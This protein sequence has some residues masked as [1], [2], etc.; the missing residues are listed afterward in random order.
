MLK[1][2]QL[3]TLLLLAIAM[4]SYA[5]AMPFLQDDKG[6]Q[7]PQ[8][9]R[10]AQRP[11]DEDKGK[12]N[13]STDILQTILIDE[14]TIPDSLLHPRWKIQRTTPITYD[15][16]NQSAMDLRRP[17]ALHYEVTYNDSLDVYVI[18]TK[19]GSTYVAAPIMMD[20]EEYMD[21]SMKQEMAIYYRGK[22]SEIYEAKGK[23]KFD[24]TDMHFDLGPAEKIFGPGGVRI[25]TQGTAELKLGAT[26]KNI[27]NPSLPI[28]NRKTT[29]INF[30]EKINLSVNGKVGDKVNMN[31]NYNTD[32]TFDFDSQNMK[33]KYEGKEDE[34]IKLVEAG[35]TSFPSNSSLV[36][37]T[38][39]LFG[40]RTDMQFGKL[41]LQTVV[42][43]KK[44]SS[45]S[46][47][48]KGGTQLTSF[49]IDVA[50]YE[51]NRHFFLSQYF[52]S[53]YDNGMSKLP[54]VMTGVSISR[55]EIWV[56]NKTGTTTNT[57]DIVALTDLGEPTTISNSMWTGGG[58][59]V[60]A[61][62]ANTEYA[63]MTSQ[64]ADARDI[65]QTSSVLEG[66]G[67]VGG[68]DFEKLQSARLLTSSEYTLNTALGYVSLKSTLSTDQVLAVA[69]EYTYGGVTY[70]V[71][72]FAADVTD[73]SQALFVKALK[74]TS[75]DPSQGNWDLMMKNVY[76]LAS[77]VEKEKFKLDVKYQSD[78]T[79]V[80]LNY[81]PESQVKSTTLLKVL[82]ADR[83][84]NNNKAHSNGYFDYVDGY[85]VSN[86]RVFFP[87][88]EPFGSYIYDY[89]VSAGVDAETA[90]GYAFTELYTTTKTSAKQIAEK[91]KYL[92]VGQ[93]RGTSANVISLGAYNVPQGSVTVTAGG[94]TLTEGSD[95]SV[96]YS[97]G[98]V[99]ILNQSIIDAGTTVTATYES[100]SDYGQMRKT[101][102]GLNWEYD[103]SKNFQLSGTLQHLSE[104]SL[105]TKVSMGNE[106]VNNTLWGINMNWKHE[107]QWLTNVLDKLPGLHLTQPSQISFT[108]EFAQLIAAQAGGTQ[109]NASYLDDFESSTD[110]ID[111]STPT[112]WV[113]SS[114][115]SM[116]S[117]QSDKTGLTSGYNRA[118]MAWYTIDPLFTR[119]SSSLTP[120]HIKSDLDQ[121][122]DPYVR[123]VYVKELYPNRDQSSYSGATSTLS[124]LNVAYYPTERGPYNFN[125]D[126]STTGELNNATDHWG[127]MM[128][129]L[130]TSDFE[131]ANVE[132]IE[133]WLMDPFI[134][135]RD[136]ADASSYGGDLYFNLGEV[137]EDILRDGKKFYES[138]LPV[139][140]TSSYSTTQWGKIPEQATTTYSFSTSSGTRELQDL[141]LNGLNDEEELQFSSYQ[142]FL[143]Q[144]QGK[145]NAAVWDSIYNDPAHDN[146][147]YF[148]GSDYDE[149]E[150]SILR[151]Y[152]YINNPQGNS[153]DSDGRTESYDTS[154]KTSPDVEDI[155]QD[156]TLNE[157]EKYYQY[158]VSLRPEDFVV[159][160]NFIVDKRETNPTRRNGTSGEIDWYLFRI[161][162]DEYEKVYGSI[163][164]FSS[165]RFMRMFLTGFEKPVVLRFASLDLVRG[166]WRIYDGNLESSGAQTGTLTTASMSIEENNDKTPVNYVLPPG[167]TREQD[168]TQ[169]QLVEADEQALALNVSNLASGES[170]CIY[171]NTT[172]DLR[173]YKTI[174]LFVHANALET[175]TTN[176]Q[177]DELAIFVRLGSDYKNNYYEYQ[178][179]L[180]LTPAGYYDR[181]SLSGCQ[182]VWPEENMLDVALS[183]FTSVK[184]ERNKAKA[185]GTASYT[186][187]YSVYDSDNPQNKVT[188][189]GNPTL[190]E[191]K[192]LIIGVR[193]LSA[194]TKSGEIWVNELRVKDYESSGGWAANG[195]LNVQLSDLG[196]VNVQGKYIS[197]GF[198]GLE[199]GVS[200]R[201]QDSESTFSFTTN[202]ELGKF[203]PDKANVTIP[204]YYSVTR[205]KTTP[206]YNPLD[207]DV[208][209][210]DALDDAADDAERDS[211]K[212]IAITK[213]VTTNF[214]LS[215][216]KVGIQNKKHPMPYD[217]ANFTFFYSHSHTHTQGET[218]V[219]ENEDNWRGGF[220]YLWTPVYKS[221][222]PFK[223][224][225]TKSKWADIAKKFGLN[226]LPQSVGFNTEL[227]RYYYELQERDLEA[228]ENAELPVTFSSQFLWNR[229][230][231][232]RWDFTKN[233]HMTFQS[234]TQ[235]EIEE[236]Y[237]AVNKD[238]YPERYQAWKDSVWQSI[239]HLGTPLDYQQTFQL[240]YKPP[241]NLIPIFDWVSTDAT[242][243]AAYTWERGS[244][245]E[246]STSLGNTI[247]T[248]R[249]LNV[250]GQFDLV[251]LY[252]HVPFLKATNDRFGKDKSKTQINKEKKQK[253]TEKANKKKQQEAEQKA[254]EQAIAEGKDPDE[255]VRA[256]RQ[257]QK[258]EEQKKKTLP[259][260]KRSYEK[261]ITLKPDTTID[262]QHGKK[263]KRIIVTAKTEDGKQ[264]KLKYK[265]VDPNKIRITT[266]VD[267]ATKV[268]INV[269]PKPEWDTYK[270]YR[271]AQSIARVAMM[272]RS[273]SITYRNQYSMSLPGFMPTIGDA[274]G[275]TKNNDAGLLSPGLAF[276]FG[277]VGD[278]YVNTALNNGWLLMN[279]SVATPATSN[280]TEDL[281]LRLKLEPWRHLTIDLNAAYTK[282]TAKS[283]QYMYDGCPTT[284]SGTFSMTTISI[285]SAFEGMGNAKNGYRSKTFE[286]FCNSLETYR[287][288]VE[289]RYAGTTYPTGTAYAGQTFS[290]ANGAVEQ[291]SADVMIPAF[292]ASYT[293]MGDGL[294]IFPALSRLLP[295]W[296]IKYTGLSK[297]PWLR[298]HFKSV[299][300]N[301]S[302]KSI[303]AVGSYQSYSTFVSLIGGADMGFITD[304]TTGD[305]MPSS[306]YNVSTVSLNEAFSPLL[307][308]DCTLNNGL[309][310]KLEYKQTRVLTLSMT[311]VQLN[312]T[313]SKDWVVGF[314]YK[315]SNFN[316][317]GS[318]RSRAI[319]KAQ[320]KNKG[321]GTDADDENKKAQENQKSQNS[322]GGVNHDLN[323]SLDLSLRKQASITRDIATV[324]SSASSGNTAFKLSFSAEYTLSRLLTMSFYLDRQTTTPLLSSSSYPTTTQDFGL[325]LK[326]SLTR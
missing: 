180:T 230:F 155:N 318:K 85:T 120:S 244:E 258:E 167:I 3:T 118:Q 128:R 72:E 264:L 312:E 171:K 159:G 135:S 259:L 1:K 218:T 136:A 278:D 46:V 125:P 25:K 48:S 40:I 265:K 301:H 177:D 147:H 67:L 193:N 55:V 116:F 109:D 153:P 197:E 216:M 290:A 88:V 163:S 52:R 308:I 273:A 133:F 194:N 35:N 154:Y 292:L 53:I 182:A 144:V 251:K 233:L 98:E 82:G 206:K 187:A 176:L 112:S 281:Q 107:S 71:G 54:N 69:Y 240:S 32:A 191:V 11:Q 257:K 39:S 164:D 90:E 247:T 275:Q 229:E 317:F 236:P 226:W 60:P 150:A 94:V 28:R 103:F 23:E 126:L 280:K 29:T 59:L 37:G 58:A 91:D 272:V 254:R 274:F 262:V 41:K 253:E 178:I 238:L 87:K 269:T 282:T 263:T 106:P 20:P 129:K 248:N 209:L 127:G 64:Y 314:G 34:I 117:E 4:V 93:F 131:T 174:Q 237:T 200:A 289:D 185:A 17:D 63:A 47:S 70:Q 324:T 45:S 243:N 44:S 288:R 78:T 203:F 36:Q 217:P 137:S 27:D 294:D 239:K 5:V 208:L 80:Y 81:I 250:N 279:D 149:M 101:M 102:L 234:A 21:W 210:D 304:A 57:R 79:G 16:L 145:V 172:L 189:M 132:Y 169:P 115:P 223:K 186:Q 286:K 77:S 221:W 61:N 219:Y 22:N 105:T 76:Y 138:G 51:E 122:S 143:T 33:L 170:K 139:D 211:I 97:A 322:R 148:R 267:T 298:D 284:Q 74:N 232:L 285:G 181:L 151:R 119:R 141:G 158:H 157:Y 204:L 95:Y 86:G 2:K 323:L 256:L 242:Y 156:Y 299:N 297:L 108:G 307:G 302:Y 188:I 311:S 205:E 89:L 110:K 293:S 100:Q 8:G 270:W 31:L 315:I 162:V 179:P 104:Q 295:N 75:N 195:N 202:L 65:D 255:A 228:T 241:I 121:L 49:E 166:T 271:T 6:R 130:D 325:S 214:S 252:N 15:D 198:G 300:I 309:T 42:S 319:S 231:N 321:K 175:N 207:T 96:D 83:L 225:K 196:T 68:A 146:Y 161:P 227:T 140:G 303:Y 212:N 165:I 220:N 111:V 43:Q 260:N 73:T 249:Q 306:M 12:K 215:N 7:R 10:P 134:N 266:K 320:K 305:L 18:G 296:T 50:N 261:E 213:T 123:E 246:D 19:I 192:T 222:E 190:G 235:A 310:A 13:A 66:A 173:Q 142:D 316:L 283:I 276:A 124:I 277:L 56:T 84:D 9:N 313:L 245:L 268:K 62:A 326:F 224:L 199:D 168:P 99:T 24:F 201:A 184:K 152:R 26:L 14:D 160:E 92:L 30:D 113:L 114:V 291:Y 183:L 287:Q 38:T